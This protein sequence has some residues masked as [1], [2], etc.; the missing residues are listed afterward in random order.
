[1]TFKRVSL[2]PIHSS[3]GM[4]D[5]GMSRGGQLINLFYSLCQGLR[6]AIIPINKGAQSSINIKN[7][8]H[9]NNLQTKENRL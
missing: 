8:S 5:N 2:E 3:C 1:M 4:Q 9:F 7:V 6:L